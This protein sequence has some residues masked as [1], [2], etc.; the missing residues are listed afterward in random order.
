MVMPHHL[1]E[2]RFRV[3]NEVIAKFLQQ[4]MDEAVDIS[5]SLTELEAL[6]AAA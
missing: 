2:S 4:N 1:P 6:L 5:R 3:D